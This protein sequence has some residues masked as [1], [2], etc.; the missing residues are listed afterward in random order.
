MNKQD[1]KWLLAAAK[2]ASMD[3]AVAA[4]TKHNLSF[5]FIY[6]DKTCWDQDLFPEGD[7]AKRGNST[8]KNWHT[9]SR[10]SHNNVKH[11]H[12]H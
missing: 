8:R 6:L 12:S 10:Q 7:L 9:K 4:A 3:D 2:G 1:R 11:K 5:A